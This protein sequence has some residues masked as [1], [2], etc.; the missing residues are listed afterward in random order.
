MCFHDNMI[1]LFLHRKTSLEVSWH[2][3][4]NQVM[5]KV[6]CDYFYSLHNE[7]HLPR[8]GQDSSVGSMS[9]S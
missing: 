9:A 1:C 6:I 5:T 3:G 4:S 7:L 2:G 8:M